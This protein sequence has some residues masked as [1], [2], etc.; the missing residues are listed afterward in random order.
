[1]YAAP[2]VLVKKRDG[3]YRFVCDYRK[4]NSVTLP[5]SWPLPVFVDVVDYIANS[6]A[7]IFSSL[8]LANGFFQVLLHE[9]SKHKTAFVTHQGLYQFKKPEVSTG[10]VIRYSSF[11]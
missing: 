11:E 10:F 6:K 9:D 2:F 5:M 7:Q 8:D 3:S 4:L 1:M